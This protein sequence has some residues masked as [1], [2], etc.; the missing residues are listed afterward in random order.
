MLAH[1]SDTLPAV[2]LATRGT[3]VPFVYRSIGDPRYWSHRIDRRVRVGA[4]LRRARAVVAT[5]AGAGRSLVED[6][7]LDP[8]RVHVIPNGRPLERFPEPTEAERV[9][10]RRSVL[11]PDGDPEAPTVLFLGTLAAE[12][13]P[14]LAV[15]A[16]AQLPGVHLLVAGSGPLRANVEQYAGTVA[17]G[18]VHLLGAVDD[19]RPVLLAADV[20]VIPSR[21]EGFPGV[22]VEAGLSG[23][24]V[25]STDVG[26]ARDIVVPGE[27]G[28]IADQ[29][30]AGLL[31]ALLERALDDRARLGTNARRRCEAAFSLTVVADQWQALLDDVLP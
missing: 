22:A 26:A 11:G 29:R 20:V 2:F 10:A 25:V 17:P 12:K 23:L 4:Q 27:T 9:D 18:R 8:D 6:H 15:R 5:F 3:G 31:A 28:F 13:A 30:D 16:I 21:S 19:P 7:G 24:P 14:E 1:G